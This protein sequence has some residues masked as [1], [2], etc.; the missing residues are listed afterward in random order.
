MQLTQSPRKVLSPALF[1]SLNVAT[2]Q[3]HQR[4]PK[5][6]IPSRKK[7]ESTVFLKQIS[8]AVSTHRANFAFNVG[9]PLNPH[10]SGSS[11]LL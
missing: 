2:K 11:N 3:E 4:M 10:I 6:N 8:S 1:T 7:Y 5:T 9:K